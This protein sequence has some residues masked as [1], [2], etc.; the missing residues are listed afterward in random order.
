MTFV[1][2]APEARSVAL[3]GDFDGWDA[4]RLPMRREGSGLWTVDVPLAPGR[5]QYA[6]VVDGRRF[7]ADPSAPRATGDDFGTP[8]SVV[9][10]GGAARAAGGIAVRRAHRA[11]RLAGRRPRGARGG[12]RP[13]GAA[14]GRLDERT[15]AAVA[16]LVDSARAAGAA[17]RRRWSTRRS[18]ARA[19]APT[20]RGSSPPVRALAG[21]LAR[22]RA[23]LGAPPR[24]RS[25]WRG[26]RRSAPAPRR[27]SSRGCAA[28]TPAR[29]WSCRSP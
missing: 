23:A 4:A 15:R 26:R 21:D 10:V 12:A 16:A 19:R 27:R 28:T 2:L 22:A 6:F 17:R 11:A 18:R 3:A 24:S 7:V 29:R 1:F 25:S 5:Y 8:T 13:D 14:G 20:A 9:T